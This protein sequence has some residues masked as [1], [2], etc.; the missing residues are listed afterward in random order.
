[1][2]RDDVFVIGRPDPITGLTR[3][4][5]TPM[6]HVADNF[7]SN[8]RRTWHVPWPPGAA[9]YV[10]VSATY[11]GVESDE[12]LQEIHLDQSLS[13]AEKADAQI[14]GQTALPWY[15]VS[16]PVA[17]F[18]LAFAVVLMTRL[19]EVTTG[20]AA[21]AAATATATATAIPGVTQ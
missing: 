3:G 20:P 15:Y 10:A 9:P 13:A 6:S 4:Y 1:M 14:A 11:G 2:K 16:A 21:Q 12:E 19:Q 17:A 18:L 8:G 7:W 5:R